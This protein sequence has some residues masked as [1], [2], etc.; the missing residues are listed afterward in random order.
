MRVRALT[1]HYPFDFPAVRIASLSCFWSDGLAR[2]ASTASQPSRFRARLISSTV[3]QSP[4]A[5][6]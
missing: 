3:W 2:C 6:S 1:F 5:A 4:D